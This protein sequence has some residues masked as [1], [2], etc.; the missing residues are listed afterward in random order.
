MRVLILGATGMLGHKLMQVLSENFEV[1]GTVRGAADDYS[2]H[3]LLG[4]MKLIGGVNADNFGSVRDAINISK[5]DVIVNCIGIVK[6][7]P[8]AYDAIS[9]IAINALFPHQVAHFCHPYGIRL[10]H[11]STD[12]VFTGVKGN[13]TEDALS[14]AQDLYGRTKF[15]GEVYYD[16]CLTLRT[17]LI[18]RELADGHSLIEWFISQ[19][20]KSVKGFKNAIFTGLTTKAHADILTKILLNFPDMRGLWHLSSDPINKYELLSLV[21]YIYQLDIMIEPD[22][23]F[24]IDRSL[25]ADK[26]RKNIGITIPGWDEMIN[27]MYE[28]EETYETIRKYYANR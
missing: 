3:P 22:Y 21:K 8:E 2:D 14:D 18:G 12:C 9:S 4:D 16:N 11:Y 5:P 24:T 1:T 10:I 17:S 26:F 23:L 7:L 25:N 20:G 27:E 13:Y 15:L 28:D 19:T 6:Q